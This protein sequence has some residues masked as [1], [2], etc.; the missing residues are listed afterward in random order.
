M[1]GVRVRFWVESALAALSIVLALVTTIQR[2]WIERVFGL[3]PDQ[4][5][6][7]AE[8]L[9]VLAALTVAVALTLVARREWRR[10]QVLTA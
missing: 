10:H 8:W 7:A 2:D 3:D 5:I 6:G 4:H 1:T 9:I